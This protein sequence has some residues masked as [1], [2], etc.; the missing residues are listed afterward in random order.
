MSPPSRD[1]APAR[2]T[3]SRTIAAPWPARR[4]S[5]RS[6]ARRD[7]EEGL[8]LS[9]DHGRAL[10]RRG[11]RLDAPG[12]VAAPEQPAH[13]CEPQEAPDAPPDQQGADGGNIAV[14][15]IVPAQ[16]DRA[17]LHDEGEQ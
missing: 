6:I 13:P 2:P 11:C 3:S 5:T 16:M 9:Q 14:D 10:S 1:R 7:I 17:D 4:S 8:A 12:N 15:R